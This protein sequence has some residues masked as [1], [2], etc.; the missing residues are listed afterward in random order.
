MPCWNAGTT[1]QKNDN[2]LRGFFGRIALQVQ[3]LIIDIK[4]ATYLVSHNH[5]NLKNTDLKTLIDRM[6]HTNSYHI[7]VVEAVEFE[8]TQYEYIQPHTDTLSRT[9]TSR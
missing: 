8:Y 5:F 9:H 3:F 6:K 7:K 1:P 4:Y 2:I